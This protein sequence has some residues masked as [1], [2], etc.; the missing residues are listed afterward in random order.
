MWV[1]SDSIL[2]ELTD[3]VQIV[4]PEIFRQYSK[5]KVLLNFTYSKLSNIFL[6]LE[7]EQIYV[8]IFKRKQ[9][10]FLLNHDDNDFA[11]LFPYSKVKHTN[12]DLVRIPLYD[13]I[14]DQLSEY[15]HI[16][17]PF[18]FPSSF[19]FP[20]TMEMPKIHGKY[21][22]VK[23]PDVFVIEQYGIGIV[24]VHKFYGKGNSIYIHLFRSNDGLYRLYV[25]GYAPQTEYNCEHVIK[26]VINDIGNEM[27][28]ELLLKRFKQHLEPYNKYCCYL[29]SV[30]D[31]QH[32][33]WLDTLLASDQDF[34]KI[35]DLPTVII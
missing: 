18:S 1:L 10:V 33:L 27:T 30:I 4:L 9:N 23:F 16:P 24:T 7:Q 19:P 11:T 14:C 17:F 21:T 12:Q 26:F 29:K 13:S 2:L 20:D 6:V 15:V 28:R 31:K 8:D 5:P 35:I 32:V 22:N 34:N 3:N 25:N